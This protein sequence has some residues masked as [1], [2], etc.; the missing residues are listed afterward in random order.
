MVCVML[1]VKKQMYEKSKAHK[2]THSEFL[3]NTESLPQ[4]AT[5]GETHSTGRR[6]V[7]VHTTHG[8]SIRPRPG[9]ATGRSA[10]ALTT[11]WDHPTQV[12]EDGVISHCKRKSTT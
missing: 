1:N 9:T 8:M 10:G 5:A 12:G 11:S 2:H 4:S 6:R 3:L 7:R